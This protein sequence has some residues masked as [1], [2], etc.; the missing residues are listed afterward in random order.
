[1]MLPFSRLFGRAE[2]R[3]PS[4]PSKLSSAASHS[5]SR[6]LLAMFQARPLLVRG[7]AFLARPTLLASQATT[8]AS[9]AA[10]LP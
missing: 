8:R 9:A 10:A 4:C 3:V 2:V 6:R 1:M 5:T 7:A